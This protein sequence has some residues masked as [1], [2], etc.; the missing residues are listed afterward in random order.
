MDNRSLVSSLFQIVGGVILVLALLSHTFGN[1]EKGSELEN[2]TVGLIFLYVIGSLIILVAVLGAYG[3][4][5]ENKA[6]LIVFLVCMIAG[7]LMM[8]RGGIMVATARPQVSD[9]MER[10]FRQQIP[11][12]SAPDQ[13]QQ[14][15]NYLQSESHCCGLFSYRDWEEVPESCSC[16]S[17]QAPGE[18]QQ[19]RYPVFMQKSIY[20]QPCF[21]IILG[22]ALWAIDFVLGFFFVLAGLAVVGI[23]L[24]SVLIHQLRYRG[25]PAV[26]V[27][28]PAVYTAAPPK[29]QELQNPPKYQE[30]QNP[31]PY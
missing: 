24:S 22:Y 19:F 28:V 27:T 7:S 13:V 11:L 31:P 1:L 6:S 29:Y 30:L 10:T 2:Q 23:L 14:L 20:K 5:K 8:F 26:L 17:D 9:L 3:A 18:C 21:P 25:N 16:R 12:D 4:S 15:V